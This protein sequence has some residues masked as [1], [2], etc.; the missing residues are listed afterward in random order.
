MAR[1]VSS[2]KRDRR[3]SSRS[4]ICC[5]TKASRPRV[6][7]TVALRCA[8]EREHAGPVGAKIDRLGHEAARAPQEGR[9]AVDHRQHAV[10]GAR[11]DGAVMA[12]DEIG[13]A[14]SWRAPRRR[15]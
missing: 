5:E 2:W 11:D 4:P 13:D 3:A 12:D 15:R 7:V 14:A 1:S 8:A 10:V 6:T 9:R